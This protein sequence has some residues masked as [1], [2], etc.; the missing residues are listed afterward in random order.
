MNDLITVFK[1]QPV[2]TSLMVAEH[3][4]KRHKHV[5]RAIEKAI[6]TRPKSGPSEK[7]FF[8]STYR[9][10]SGRKV[11]MYYLNRDGFSFI[12]MGFTGEKANAWKWKYIEA[13][14]Q[15]ERVLIQK[16]SPAWNAVREYAKQTRKIETDAIKQFTEYAMAQGSKHATYYYTSITRM[17]NAALGV[18]D[19]DTLT[20]D[21]MNRLAIVE[22]QVASV[23]HLAMANGLPYKS[24][25]KV[26]KER[27]QAH[28]ALLREAE[29]ALAIA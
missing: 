16:A 28:V 3:F 18:T 19:R 26:I 15:M 2:T 13:F 25:Y 12:V 17:T 6:L 20:I 1:T 29:N 8:K 14:N 5:L 9:D 11:P 23:I 10:A 27:V 24:I 7:P 22:S 4:G 21:Q